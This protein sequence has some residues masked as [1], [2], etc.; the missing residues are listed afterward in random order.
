MTSVEQCDDAMKDGNSF[1]V[2]ARRVLSPVGEA[3]RAS[4]QTLQRGLAPALGAAPGPGA[5]PR[6]PPPRGDQ[7]LN[8][9]LRAEFAAQKTLRAAAVLVPVIMRANGLQILL[10]QRPEHMKSHAGQISFPGGKVERDDQ[11]M[12]DT[13]LRETEEEV[14]ITRNFIEPVGLLERYSTGT[15]FDITPVVALVQPEFI[16]KIDPNEVAEAFEVPL[17]FLMDDNRYETHNWDWKGKTYFFH[18]ISYGERYI[19][20]ATAGILRNLS[21]RLRSV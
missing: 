18:A 3:L 19:W 16:L 7:D 21:E 2:Q 13:A 5:A 12:I 10:T 14:G 20:G 15:G 4:S 9:G 17:R 6:T 11:N 8:P 1:A